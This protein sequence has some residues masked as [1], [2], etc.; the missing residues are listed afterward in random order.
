MHNVATCVCH[1]R[2]VTVTQLGDVRSQRSRWCSPTVVMA[3]AT[4][5]AVVVLVIQI[6]SIGALW[7][8]VSRA[9][10]GWLL[11]ALAL[12][13]VT[14]VGFAIALMGTVP[15]RLL[16]WPTTKVQVAMSF[17]NLAIPG[18]G[19]TAMQVR[20]LHKQGVC[21][22]GAVACGG[23]LAPVASVVAQCV[24][25]PVALLLSPTGVELG[26]IPTDG[27]PEAVLVVALVIGIVTWLALRVP[28]LRRVVVPPVCSALAAMREALR[29]PRR[30]AQ[31]LVGNVFVSVLYAAC[32]LMCVKAYGGDAP[33]G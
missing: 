23:I 12:S 9:E 20:F 19:G 26:G 21:L 32:L 28:A 1:R 5:V 13:L 15:V 10:S 2:A 11:G 29:S 27:L 22:A 16:L 33:F 31:L 14:N 3:A 7:G 4:L 17:S 8:T 30:V 24:L 18:I 25:F 6:G